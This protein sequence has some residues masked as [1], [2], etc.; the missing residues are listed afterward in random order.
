M[1]R[2][3]E[4]P[5]LGLG[6]VVRVGDRPNLFADLYFH[7]IQGSWLT[8]L[9]LLAGSYVL[10]NVI[11][12]ALYLLDP[13][14]VQ[15]L[16]RSSL[17]QAFFFSVQTMA[18]VGYGTMAPRSTYA[19]LLSTVEAVLGLA[20]FAMATALMFAKFARPR[21]NVLFSSVAVVT[22][23]HGRPCL[24]FRAANTRGNEVVEAALSVAALMDEVSPE[25]IRLRRMHDLKLV[26]DRSLIFTLSWLVIHPLDEKSPLRGCDAEELARRRV[27]VIATMTGFD[28]TFAQTVH[29]RHVYRAR[30]L[31]WGQRFVDVLSAL[32]DGRLQIDLTHFH[33]TEADAV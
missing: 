22:Q 24:M 31:R 17:L 15:N 21:A 1:A 19:H 23:F 6:E 7:L 28:S 13:G 10:V 3:R 27:V 25:G 14:G 11:F 4:Q 8:L 12:A 20:G 30:D 5:D 2:E 16:P 32:P 18:T 33:Q 29:A 26:R 9:A